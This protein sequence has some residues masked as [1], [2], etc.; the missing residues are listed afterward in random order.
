MEL[1]AAG[2]PAPGGVADAGEGVREREG[3]GGAGGEIGGVFLPARELF[4][5]GRVRG[6]VGDAIAEEHHPV[7]FEAEDVVVISQQVPPEHGRAV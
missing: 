1:P 6:A 3:L 7:A 5:G 2:S 4:G